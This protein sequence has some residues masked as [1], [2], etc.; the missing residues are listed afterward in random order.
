[1]GMKGT[2][3]TKQAVAAAEEGDYHLRLPAD[4]NAFVKTFKA[5]KGFRTEVEAVKHIVRERR[6]QEVETA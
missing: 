6:E 2:K 5:A 4:L 1:M 3:R